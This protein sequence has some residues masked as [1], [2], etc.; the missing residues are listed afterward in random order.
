MDIFVSPIGLSM[1]V[2]VVLGGP[3]AT[4]A[5]FVSPDKPAA[6]GQGTPAAKNGGW[7][8]ELLDTLDC[9]IRIRPPPRPP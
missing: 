5:R 4:V 2:L 9:C 7:E 8:P 6:W 1:L 3:V